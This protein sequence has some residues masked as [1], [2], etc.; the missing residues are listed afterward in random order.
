MSYYPNWLGT[1][2]IEGNLF[3]DRSL[4]TTMP[5]FFAQYTLHDS[6]WIGLFLEPQ[7]NGIA[8]IR[9]DTFWTKGRMSFPGST[10]ADWHLLLIY[11]SGLCYSDVNLDETGISGATTKLLTEQQYQTMVFLPEG[12][13][14][15][16]EIEDFAGGI[17]RFIHSSQVSL[18][19][20]N[21]EKE[22]L[23]IPF[24]QAAA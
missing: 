9:W 11:F 13:F 5:E 21:K 20:L 22:I 2:L 14:H 4:K 17:A 23:E 16:T 15:C 3:W 18:L 7:R 19:C 10:V 12:E 1:D 8:I 24:N 6:Y